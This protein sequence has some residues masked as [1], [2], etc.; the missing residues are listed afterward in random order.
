MLHS[1]LDLH[2]AVTR[3][4]ISFLVSFAEVKQTNTDVVQSTAA[5][6][7]VGKENNVALVMQDSQYESSTPFS[8]IYP[9]F[10]FQV[11]TVVKKQNMV[12]LRIFCGLGSSVSDYYTACVFRRLSEDECMFV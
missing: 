3:R 2:A 1:L 4:T 10:V 8:V 5:L 12:K 6:N 11:F 7:T 9:S